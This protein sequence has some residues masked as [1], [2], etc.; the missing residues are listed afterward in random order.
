M[1]SPKDQVPCRSCAK[2][3]PRIPPCSSHWPG[4]WVE[5]LN[6]DATVYGGSGLG[7]AAGVTAE[8]VPAHGH[9]QSVMLTLPPLSTLFLRSES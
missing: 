5:S 1:R 2:P 7:N 4:R 6:S 3:I 8:A 9:P